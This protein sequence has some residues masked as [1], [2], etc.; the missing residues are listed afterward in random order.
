MIDVTKLK[1]E[2]CTALLE[3]VVFYQVMLLLWLRSEGTNSARLTDDD[4]RVTPTHLLL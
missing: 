1:D 3:Q 2:L 4:G